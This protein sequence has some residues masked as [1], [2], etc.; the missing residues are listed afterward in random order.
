M[1]DYKLPDYLIIRYNELKYQIRKRLD[2]FKQFKNTLDCFYELCFCLCTP[3]SKAKNAQKVELELR[4]RDFYNKPFNPVRLLLKKENYIRFHN[5]KAS[6][7][8]NVRKQFPS[9]IQILE[10]NK[11]P[12]EKRI[13]LVENINGIGMKEASH[14]LRNIGYSGL[15]IF[16]RHILKHLVECGLYV[17][18]PDIS[19][20]K[21][22]LEIEQDFIEFS[23]SIN[24]SIDELD[25]LFWGYETGV[26]LK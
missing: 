4:K 18:L 16:D 11:S 25:L 3:Q 13:W 23:R 24:I 19:S 8:I 1:S 15:A 14:Y 17:E 7:L 20:I 26:I 2:E 12:G 6:R 10:S 9:I 21:K 5:Q 22:Y